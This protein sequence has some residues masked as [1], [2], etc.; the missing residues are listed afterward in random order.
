MKTLSLFCPYTIVF[1]RVTWLEI[2]SQFVA[3]TK[4]KA[5][6]SKPKLCPVFIL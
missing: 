1:L 5:K 3:E 4:F 6:L 2:H